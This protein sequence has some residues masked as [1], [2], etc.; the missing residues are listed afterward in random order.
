M[1]HNIVFQYNVTSDNLKAGQTRIYFLWIHEDEFLDH[2]YQ[3]IIR[4]C[5]GNYQYCDVK[6]RMIMLKDGFS[7]FGSQPPHGAWPNLRAGDL[8]SSEE[9]FK[10][11][12][13][14]SQFR[15]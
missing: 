1:V 15:H 2:N 13:E 3:N 5:N 11:Q 14:S 4:C 7:S 8:P 10:T 9:L 6:H 12:L